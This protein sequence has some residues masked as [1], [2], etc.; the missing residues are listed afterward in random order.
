MR[1]EYIHIGYLKDFK[2]E[3]KKLAQLFKK[4]K[5]EKISIFVKRENAEENYK[6]YFHL[7]YQKKYTC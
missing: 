7:D 5:K 1:E 3:N 6:L 4:Y 2:I